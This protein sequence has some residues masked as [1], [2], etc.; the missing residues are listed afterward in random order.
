[1]LALPVFEGL[2]QF[3]GSGRHSIPVEQERLCPRPFCLESG[4]PRIILLLVGPDALHG[5]EIIALVIPPRV[6]KHSLVPRLLHRFEHATNV[7]QNVRVLVLSLEP[8]PRANYVA[9]AIDYAVT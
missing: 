9:N 6:S 8:L 7:G 1:M 3:H 4:L 5:W 2:D